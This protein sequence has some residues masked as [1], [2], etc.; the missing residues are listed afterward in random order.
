MKNRR[1]FTLIEILTVLVILSIISLVAV[2]NVV[3]MVEKNKK[4]QMVVD[5]KEML[6]KFLNYKT[7]G[8]CSERLSNYICEYSFEELGLYG[9]SDGFGDEYVV[10][11]VNYNYNS[12]EY[13]IVLKTDKHC[14][15]DSSCKIV[16]KND[17]EFNIDVEDVVEIN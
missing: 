3:N 17:I 10:G 14:I 5:T 15:G 16:T 11:Y 6:N 7:L 12:K 2:P 9:K 4:K 1:G 13:S 8:K